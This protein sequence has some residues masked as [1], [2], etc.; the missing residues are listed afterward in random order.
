MGR[1]RRVTYCVM[2]KSWL[3]LLED[4]KCMWGVVFSYVSTGMSCVGM[5]MVRFE[6]YNAAVTQSVVFFLSAARPLS[7]HLSL[8]PRSSLLHLS[9]CLYLSLCIRV[10]VCMFMC[11]QGSP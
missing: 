3:G 6:T 2:L 1:T 8:I 11:M 4:L 7:F 10:C 9:V 5:P